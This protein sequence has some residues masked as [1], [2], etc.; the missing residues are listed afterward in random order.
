MKYSL[1]KYFKGSCEVVSDLLFS[2]KY[3]LNIAFVGDHITQ[4]VL[5]ATGMNGL[6]NDNLCRFNPSNGE[7]TFVQSTWKQCFLKTN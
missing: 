7:A 2:F 1:E 6:S 3:F 5:T 4:V